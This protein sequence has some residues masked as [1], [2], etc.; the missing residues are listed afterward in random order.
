MKLAA[1]IAAVVLAMIGGCVAQDE[2]E[3]A[4]QAVVNEPDPS[5]CQY[6]EA[7]ECEWWTVGTIGACLTKTERYVVCQHAAGSCGQ[8][9][10]SMGCPVG[11][12]SAASCV[13]TPTTNT[14]GS[15]PSP[16]PGT[17]GSCKTC[18]SLGEYRVVPEDHF[19]FETRLPASYAE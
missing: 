2:S 1:L 3:L 19:H 16:H 10:A 6:L 8:P 9:H 7:T 11:A 13:P 14:C 18:H 4:Q 12:T 5:K 17:T 15:G